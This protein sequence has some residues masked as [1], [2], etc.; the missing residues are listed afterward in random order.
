MGTIRILMSA[1]VTHL[2]PMTINIAVHGRPLRMFSTGYI[3][4]APSCYA[5]HRFNLASTSLI[6]ALLV[7]MSM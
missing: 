4:P 1:M 7:H 3:Y 6:I 2:H 5:Y